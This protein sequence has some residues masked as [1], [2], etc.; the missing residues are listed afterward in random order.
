MK[1]TPLSLML[2]AKEVQIIEHTTVMASL[3]PT[4]SIAF[5]FKE[6]ISLNMLMEKGEQV[7]VCV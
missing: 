3:S 6:T 5:Y 2:N 7:T 4:A 1:T